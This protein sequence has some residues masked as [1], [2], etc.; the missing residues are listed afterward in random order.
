MSSWVALNI[1]PDEAIEEE[2]DDTK[3]IQ[4]EEA[5]KLY[6][7]ALKLHSQGPPFYN[8]AAEAYDALLNSEIFKYPE[9]LS[10]YKRNALQD[11]DQLGGDYIAGDTAAEPL[12][13]FDIN[14]STSSTLMQTIY[15]SYKNHGQYTLDSLRASI[16]D[17]SHSDES[18]QEISTTIAERANKALSSFA[19]ALERDDTDLNLWRQSARLCSALQSYRLARYC[20][21]SVLADDENRLEVRA[22]QLGLE[23]TFAEEHL[24]ETLLSLED[25][26]SAAQVPLRKP[27]RSLLRFLKPQSDPYP[28]LPALPNNL[29][30]ADPTKHPLRSRL[31]AHEIKISILTWAAVGKA[32]LRVCGE[33]V[34]G[35]VY[36]GSR[37]TFSLPA[38]SPEMKAIT[39]REAYTQDQS[40]KSRDDDTVAEDKTHNA[41]GDNRSATQNNA[42]VKLE[43]PDEQTDDHSSIDQR[44]EK[45]LMESL[46]VQSSHSP[47]ITNRPELPNADDMEIKSSSAPRKRSSASAI[48]EDQAERIRAKSRRTRLRESNAEASLQAEEILFDQTKYYE[49]QLE[50]YTQADEWVFETTN[51]LLSK[52]GIEELTGIEELRKCHSS[53]NDDKDSP[54]SGANESECS[55]HQDLV[56]ALK[57]WDE[58]KAQAVLQGDYFSAFR[59][60]QGMGKSGL[61]VFLEHSRKSARKLGI[62]HVLVGVEELIHLLNTVNDGS[63]NIHNVAFDWLKCLL[64]PEYGNYPTE[65]VSGAP[66]FPAMKSTY[67]LFQ[68]PSELKETVVQVLLS[69]D[70][71][72]YQGMLNHVQYLERQILS[73]ANGSQ[74]TYTANHFAHLEMIETIFELQLDIYSSINNPSS[75]VNTGGRVLQ[76]D[77]LGRW[78]SLA[79]TALT[80]FMDHAPPG[81]HQKSMLLRH[82]WTSTFHS[83]MTTDTHRE[84]VLLCLEELQRLLGC[85][86]NPL[87]GLANNAAMP[88]I[89][90]EI[91]D[92]E[93]SKLKSMDFFLKIFGPNPRLS[94]DIIETIEPLLEPSSVGFTEEGESGGQEL[95]GPRSQIQEM[96]SFLDR[97]DAT[98]RLFLWRRLQAAYNDINY[99]PKEMSCYLRSI[100]VIIKELWS[101]AHL[102]EP[103]EH[104]QVTLLRW[105]KMLDGVLIKSM[106]TFWRDPTKAY[107]CFDMDHLRSSMSAIALLTKLLHGLILYEDSVRVGQTP[108]PEFRGTLAKSLE[109][110]KDNLRE[111]YVRCWILQYTLV[112]EAI[113]QN[114][115]IFDTPLDDCIHYLR[116]VHHALGIR[117]MC[118]RS[119]KDFL[120]LVKSELLTL[121]N[122]EDY[123]LDICQILYDLHGIKLLTVDNY[124]LDHGC[125]P[126][127]L[128]RAT[129]I[130]VIDVVMKQ[131]KKMN[132][133]DLSKSELK[134]TIDKMQQ[135]I[136]NTR[137]SGPLNF[138]KR[139]LTA[140]LKSP[141]NPSEI[142]RSVRGVKDVALIPIPLSIESAVIARNGWYF[143]LGYTAL[144]KFRSQKRLNPVPT[145]DLDEAVSWFRSDLEH[146]SASWETWYRLAQTYDSKLEEDITWSAE[147]INNNRT[148]LVTW[149]RYAIHCYAMAV[150]TAI[151]NADPTPETRALLSELYTDFGIRLYSSSRAPLSMGAFSLSDFTRH[152]NREENQQMYEAQPFKEMRLY[153]VWNLA[154]YLLKRAI[155][156]K[157]KSW[158]THYMYAKCLWKMFSADETVRGGAK[159]ISLDDLLDSL[160]DAIDA[161]PQKKDSRA[162]PIF[163]PHFKLVSIVHKLVHRGTLTAAEGSKTLLATPWARKVLLPEDDAGWKTY[164][165]A[166]IRNLRHADKSN[167][168]HRMA[169]RAAHIIY[170]DSKDAESAA[171]AKGE[172][173]QQIFTKTMTIQVWRPEYE[174]PG[175]H[176]VY[177]TRYV[178]YFVALLDQL[179]DRANLDQ[180]L[181]RVRKKQGDFINH[182]KLWEDV[183][184]TYARVIRRAGNITEGYEEGV[185]RPIGW[186]EF[187]LNTARLEGLQQ[188]APES[189]SLLEL[190]RDAVELK[191]LN[192][193]LMKV[194]LLEDLIADL[195]SRLYEVNMPQV[196]EQANEEHKEKMKVDHLLMGSDGA[197]DTP[198][199]P[200]SAPASE[201]PAPRGRTKGI[202]RRDIQKRAET[203]VNRKLAPRL[204]TSKAPAPVESSDPSSQNHHTE[205]TSSSITSAPQQSKDLAAH[206]PATT[207]GGTTE[208][209]TSG[210]QSDIPHSVHD[211]ADDESELSEMDDEK[212]SKLAIDRKLMFPN[213]QER[214]SLDPESEMSALEGGGDGDITI[215][216]VGDADLGE[217]EGETMGEGDDVD[218][219][220]GE[221]E[222]EGDGEEGEG[223][224]EPE[225]EADEAGAADVDMENEG[226]GEGEGE[227][228]HDLE[229]EGEG[230][231]EEEEEAEGEGD[232][233]DGEGNDSVDMVGVEP[234]TEQPDASELVSEAEPMD[235]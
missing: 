70:E 158:M 196:L 137:S 45:Q 203:I 49:D 8:E 16:E 163:E 184:L 204:P 194:S 15:L 1:E 186:E 170:D 59:D 18:T 68:W 98:L 85:L 60:I 189:G 127:K 195:Y 30:D 150:S 54:F 93:I 177:T 149:Q 58:G 88:E 103:S 14:D 35:E 212:L 178:Y 224:E 84:H 206:A 50:I 111:M 218:D 6:Q 81:D 29:Q 176:F 21:E 211:S 120:K 162:E 4:I 31:P 37:I 46:E 67:T 172:L 191:K 167:W 119:R 87:I 86:G 5:L 234:E 180:L 141:L 179:N 25:R 99:P 79:R 62:K 155:V 105:L 20:L 73:T 132:I 209:P 116:A 38:L 130:T 92:Q 159:P 109:G 94:V 115:E 185:F 17:A 174:R 22:E 128:D 233:A 142:F 192:N 140:Y 104:R 26:I 230:D 80:H 52:F 235:V 74:F 51:S 148:E 171:R 200:T 146:G 101:S 2:V 83:N 64:M 107:D 190:L 193:N 47:E 42:P 143:L 82:I 217:G 56:N 11:T 63:F 223:D 122:K 9:S 126:E 153:S 125:P 78:C 219:G 226:E 215:G 39:T 57:R 198:T 229:G 232:D 76:R 131:A 108:R 207:A 221:G 145:N 199:P 72:I 227:D 181:R 201:A 225:V 231:G 220:E 41:E 168:H 100:E 106:T 113:A 214:G 61:A 91:I 160:L 165:L 161:L 77:R 136:G 216:P 114:K 173:T 164:I 71:Y 138:N 121:E 89:S 102:Q 154:S 13:E 19:E 118:K 210:Q 182:T 69:E 32:I 7:N 75:E 110:F 213:L 188:L 95:A 183:C 208:D 112:K 33:E 187:V 123:E 27:K 152:Y 205:P 48:T 43:A 97:G 90:L 65:H 55:L 144:T 3:E 23:E 28:Y 202:A 40:S 156:D 135:A 228:E 151:R 139:V 222:G 133:K 124:P 53:L 166:V 66:Y 36:T 24:R 117:K 96:G 175:R 134:C 12:A 44:A 147:K 197:A 169:L 157:P 34:Q 10:D 129:A